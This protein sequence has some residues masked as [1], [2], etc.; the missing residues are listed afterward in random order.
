MTIRKITP[1]ELQEKMEKDDKVLL[2]DVRAE[3][4][5]KASHI[6][7]TKWNIPKTA[8]FDMEEESISLLPK[9]QEIVVTCTTGNSATKCAEILSKKDY[10][11]LVLEGGLTA[12]KDYINP[13]K[14]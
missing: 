11:V 10:N 6:E 7:G 2:L 5:Y 4:K 3:E 12:W 13:S 9:G 14:S 8:I 1:K